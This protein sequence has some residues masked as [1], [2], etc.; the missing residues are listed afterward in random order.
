RKKLSLKSIFD[1]L[2]RFDV[3]EGFSHMDNPESAWYGILYDPN[4]KR[5][6]VSGKDLATK[7]IVYLVGGIEDDMDRAHL[8]QAVAEARTFED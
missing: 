7:L 1:K 3:D 5:V 4:K 6:L 8:R 2:R